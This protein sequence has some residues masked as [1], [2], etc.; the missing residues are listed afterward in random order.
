MSA[1]AVNA[2][3]LLAIVN[4]AVLFI[5]LTHVT[6]HVAWYLYRLTAHPAAPAAPGG[7]YLTYLVAAPLLCLGTGVWLVFRRRPR[8][9]PS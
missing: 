6:F 5:A 9:R 8:N 2:R 4:A 7:I 3:L 1:V